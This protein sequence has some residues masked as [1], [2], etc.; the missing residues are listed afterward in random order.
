MKKQFLKHAAQFLKGFLSMK[1]V[2]GFLAMALTCFFSFGANAQSPSQDISAA[3]FF[4]DANQKAEYENYISRFAELVNGSPYSDRGNAMEA[5]N[6][7]CNQYKKSKSFSAFPKWTNEAVDYLCK[8]T[9]TMEA[10]LIKNKK[11]LGFGHCKNLEKAISI[12]EA[13]K[14]RP[15]YIETKKASDS[16]VYNMKK[17]LNN[18]FGH[19]WTG[20]W[21]GPD[22]YDYRCD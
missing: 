7:K 4:K 14:E 13:S 18:T 15:E 12:F 3:S 2:F 9:D 10:L 22:S 17:A 21:W 1:K 16:L 5:I 6:I 11:P 19:S 20:G 8:Y